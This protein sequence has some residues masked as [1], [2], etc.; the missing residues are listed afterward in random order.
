MAG[1]AL[2]KDD[3]DPVTGKVQYYVKPGAFTAIVIALSV[4]I[5]IPALRFAFRRLVLDY[6]PEEKRK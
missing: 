3:K 6:K 4:I 1:S 2:E 5:I